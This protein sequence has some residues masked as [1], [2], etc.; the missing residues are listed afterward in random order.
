M[1][2]R[3]HAALMGCGQWQPLMVPCLPL[4]LP[5]A[6]PGG[7]KPLIKECGGKSQ[8]CQGPCQ[9]QPAQVEGFISQVDKKGE[10]GMKSVLG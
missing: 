2:Q 6:F 10:R 8:S 4:P 3:S 1:F 5:A 9:V 7:S